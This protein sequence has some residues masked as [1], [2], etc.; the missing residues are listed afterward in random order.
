M[1]Q[2]IVDVLIWLSYEL[3]SITRDELD[4]CFISN[5]N[6]LNTTLNSNV[7]LE[8][9][10]AIIRCNQVFAR[11]APFERQLKPF[12][13]CLYTIKPHHLSNYVRRLMQYHYSAICSFWYAFYID[14]D[15]QFYHSCNARS[16][17]NRRIIIARWYSFYLNKELNLLRQE[18]KQ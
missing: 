16:Y 7:A 12:F 1:I 9:K 4:L 2:N 14:P 15:V 10:F 6:S 17:I 13:F 8:E 18:K 11:F 5:E 3:F